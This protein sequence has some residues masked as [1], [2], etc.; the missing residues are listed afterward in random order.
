[1]HK[2]KLMHFILHKIKNTGRFISYWMELKV[3]NLHKYTHI[4][5]WDFTSLIRKTEISKLRTKQ[6]SAP[7][8]IKHSPSRVFIQQVDVLPS[9]MLSTVYQ[10]KAELLT[11]S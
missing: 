6:L 4:F 7:I 3:W 8:K 5:Q 10:T 2:T 1:M 11:E 9:Y